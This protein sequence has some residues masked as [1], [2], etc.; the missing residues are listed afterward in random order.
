M[1]KMTK[2]FIA[3][4]SF[5]LLHHVYALPTANSPVG[6]WKTVDDVTG[7]P[8]AIIQIWETANKELFGRILKVYPRPGYNQNELCLACEGEKHNKR[9]IG[10]VIIEKLR[11]N[12]ENVSQWIGG[13]IL[14]PK[15]GKVYHSQIQMTDG[16]KKLNIKGYIGLP[17]FGRSQTWYRVDS[18]NQA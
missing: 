4:F 16:G 17:L 10:L 13:R 12:K 6:L 1:K 2:I 18:L 8:K 15:N 7:K 11:Q 14:D 3:C 9:I 5:F